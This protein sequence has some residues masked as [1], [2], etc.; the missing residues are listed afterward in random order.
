MGERAWIDIT[1]DFGELS[2]WTM[3]I[4]TVAIVSLTILNW[5][6]AARMKWLTGALE[7]HSDQQRQIAAHQVGIEMRWWD[8]NIGG[9]FPH[10]GDHDQVH[11]LEKLYIGIPLHHRKKRTLWERITKCTSSAPPTS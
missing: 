2:D 11:H 9:E 8:K 6:I 1:L 4:L 10:T 3:V 5:Q 7:R